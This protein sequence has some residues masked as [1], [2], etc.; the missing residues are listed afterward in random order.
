MAE[1][2]LVLVLAEK[3]GDADR[4]RNVSEKLEL[5]MLLAC[6]DDTGKLRLDFDT[7]DSALRIVEL[8]H[9]RPLAAVLPVHD[10]AAPVAARASSMLGLPFHTPKAADACKD[11][12]LLR[13]KLAAHELAGSPDAIPFGEFLRL[14]CLMAESRL[15]VLAGFDSSGH[16]FALQ[17]TAPALRERAVTALRTLVPL[18][19]LKHGPVHVT[20]AR[21]SGVSVHDVSLACSAS[22]TAA[23][24]FRIPLVNQDMT[25]EEV[26]LRNALGLDV[27]RIYL[28]A[29]STSMR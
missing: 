16:S 3:A 27:G 1:P 11:K 9:Q 2:K 6:S 12:A 19:G 21:D 7:R 26:V 17:E 29:T 13:R 22:H 24:R 28:D 15:R 18:L 10:A 14:T 8:A 5:E 25:F 4:F 23:L 20:L